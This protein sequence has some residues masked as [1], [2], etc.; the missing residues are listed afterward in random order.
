M[1][2][3]RMVSTSP[4]MPRG[5]VLLFACASG[6]SV[7]NVYYAH[8]LLDTLAADFSIPRAAI[9]SVV[10]ATQAGCALALVLLVP[11]GDLLDRRRLM[12]AQALLLSGVLVVTGLAWSPAVLFASMLLTGAFG[13]AMT[14]G[15][16][17]YAAAAAPVHGQGRVVGAAQGGV[18]LGLLLARVMAGGISDIGGWRT[19]YLCSAA[20]M[21]VLAVSLWCGL[22]R[23]ATRPDRIR[24]LR[25]IG[26]MFLLLRNDRLL[27]VRGVLALLMFAALNIFW[28][29]MAL[30]LGAPPYLLSHAAIGAFGLVGAIGALAAARAGRW[31]DQG[32]AQPVTFAALVLLSVAWVPML[33]MDTSLWMLVVGIVLLDLGGQ[34]V[35]VT[36]QSMIFRSHPG[37]HSRV[38]A[39]YMLFYAAGSGLGALTTTAV[40]AAFGWP[41]VCLLGAGVSV[42]ALVAWAATLRYVNL[43]VKATG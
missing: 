6:L 7:A 29:A 20:A 27:Q 33:W 22:P 11:L 12:L 3:S 28:S 23:L 26:S 24:Y 14:Q 43:A 40:Y 21:L 2:A 1:Q 18:F 4:A 16:I 13:T 41:G 39:V 19:V 15:L 32:L 31:A 10:T 34:A 38:V 5:V 8:P 36:N 17:A 42:L 9:G 25:L 30:P 35:H 37:G